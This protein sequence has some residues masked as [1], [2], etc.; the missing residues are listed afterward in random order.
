MLWP[1]ETVLLQF[2]ASAPNRA[3]NQMSGAGQVTLRNERM[4]AYKEE[5]F[6]FCEPIQFQVPA[7]DG[8]TMP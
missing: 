3:L 5:P 1:A 4:G 6:L 7:V 2:P 8:A